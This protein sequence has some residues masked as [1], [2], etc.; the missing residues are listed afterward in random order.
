MK[1]VFDLATNSFV[2]VPEKDPIK[3]PKTGELVYPDS[4]PYYD[5]LES[6]EAMMAARKIEL[7]KEADERIKRRKRND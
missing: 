4:Q 1:Q 3:D 7:E 5:W 2:E 6:G